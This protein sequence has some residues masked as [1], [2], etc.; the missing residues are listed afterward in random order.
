VRKFDTTRL[1]QDL[2]YKERKGK[3]LGVEIV[4]RPAI[5]GMKRVNYHVLSCRAGGN[6]DHR[7]PY[8]QV[9]G[10]YKEGFI[11]GISK[12]IQL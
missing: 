8:S 4:T 1:Q 7:K 3:L 12:T 5:K 9:R 6:E 10:C 11:Q 2:L